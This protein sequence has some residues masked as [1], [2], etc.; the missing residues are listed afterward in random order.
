MAPQTTS[1]IASASTEPTVHSDPPTPPSPLS[2]DSTSTEFLGFEGTTVFAALPAPTYRY[3]LTLKNG[4][5]RIWLEDCDSKEQWCTRELKFD[6]YVKLSNSIPDATAADYV[7]CFREVL[8]NSHDDVSNIPSAF[9][10]H[11]NGVFQLDITVK[12]QVLRRSRVAKYSFILEPISV[13]RIDVL[14][15]KMRDLQDEVDALRE[16]GEEATA[17]HNAAVQG[18]EDVVKTLRQDL[19]DRGLIIDELRGMV[20]NVL[21]DMDNRGVMVSKLQEEVKALRVVNDSA[22]VFQAKATTKLNDVIRWE[23][24]GL[25]F[26]ASVNGVDAVVRVITPGTYHATVVVNHQAS[27]F[28]SVVQLKKGNEC[29][30]TAYCGFE[31]G[32]GGS[33]SLSCITQ[34]KKGD[35]LAVLSNASLASTS[36]LTLV[37]IDK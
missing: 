20:N 16:E 7:E 25:G 32:H 24:T 19:S 14:E 27:E 17:E 4:N 3:S 23:P 30:Q 11:K 28:N 13:E 26:G 2:E 34:V 5:L 18:L 8:D 37:R 33:T 10:H 21:Q 1:S 31:Q 12:I 35:H 29:I 15:S 22:V 9:N 6:D 36:Y